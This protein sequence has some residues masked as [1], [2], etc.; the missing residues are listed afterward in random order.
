M[1][2]APQWGAN[3]S[4]FLRY[5]YESGRAERATEELVVGFRV[6]GWVL[7]A[8]VGFWVLGVGFWGFII[9]TAKLRKNLETSKS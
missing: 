4:F 2:A 3:H 8:G 9:D 5:R 6:L 1:A 7:G